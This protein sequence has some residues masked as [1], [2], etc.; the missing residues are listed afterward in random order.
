MKKIIALTLTLVFVLAA[1]T[2]LTMTASAAELDLYTPANEGDVVFTANFHG[3]P[4]EWE[5]AVFMG[6]P[7]ATPNTEGT[8]M[9]FGSSADKSKNYW[10]AEITSLPLNEETRYTI[11]YTITRTNVD[12]VGV[13]CDTVYGAYGYAVRNKLMNQGSSLAGHDYVYYANVGID[14]PAAADG[15]TLTQDFALE[16]NGTNYAITLYIKNN[17]GE[18]VLVDD[19]GFD[20]IPFF[21]SDYMG[22]YFYNYYSAHTVTVSNCYIVKGLSFGSYEIPET[23]PAPETTAAPETTPAPETTAAPE[24]EAPATEAP[25]TEAPATEAPATEAPVTEAP[26]AEGGCGGFVALGVIAA[27]I[28][29][30]VV[31]LKK[32]N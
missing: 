18:Y 7:V 2:S 9:T 28:P 31:V 13:Y 23:T 6:S 27:L 11:Y 30:A 26:K 20:A 21:N 16:I 10:G 8:E 25:A 24:T 17:A 22:L 12:S 32:R 29:A 19:S 14:A 1:L 4:G 15:E 3:I 5:P